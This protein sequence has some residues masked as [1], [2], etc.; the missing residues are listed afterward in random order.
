[1]IR[2][3]TY[4]QITTR[5]RRDISELLKYNAFCVLS[6]GVNNKAGSLFAPYEFF[7]GWN[8]ITGYETKA[9]TGIDTTTSLVHGML[10]HARLCDIIH[11]FIYFPDTKIGRASCRE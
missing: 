2:H 3:D 5:Y 11:H 1:M 7:Y 9:L 10:N 6:D 8:K 4:K